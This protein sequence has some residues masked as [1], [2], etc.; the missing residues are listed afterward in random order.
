MAACLPTAGLT[1]GI[2]KGCELWEIVTRPD[3]VRQIE[4]IQIVD[5]DRVLNHICTIHVRPNIIRQWKLFE[6]SDSAT[7]FNYKLGLE[8]REIYHGLF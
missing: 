7:Y 6:L 2:G 1:P 4:L 5:T 3:Y 8:V